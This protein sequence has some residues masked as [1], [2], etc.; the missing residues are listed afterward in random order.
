ME[1]NTS[2]LSQQLA[3]RAKCAHPTGTFIEFRKE[4]IEQSVVA[5]FE[6]Q[7]R[8]YPDRLAVKTRTQQLTYAELNQAANRTA[9][10]IL[11]ERGVAQ[12]PIALLF[13]KGVPLIIAIFS[14]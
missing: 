8:K 7:V 5:R 13:P 12:E 9:E 6:Q 10:A 2:L 4:E 1:N 3:I 11:A 14:A